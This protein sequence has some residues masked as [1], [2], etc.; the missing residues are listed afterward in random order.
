M[1]AVTHLQD[2][3]ITLQASREGR[4]F[5]GASFKAIADGDPLWLQDE[6]I[7]QTANLIA[8]LFAERNPAD[9]SNLWAD[10]EA[11]ES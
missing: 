9:V 2:G 11:G 5:M 8:S 1:I 6:S 10:P 4:D 3:R 7:R